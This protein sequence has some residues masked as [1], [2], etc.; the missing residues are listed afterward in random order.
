MTISLI[1]KVTVTSW[2]GVS[3]SVMVIQKKML[4][5]MYMTGVRKTN[6]DYSVTNNYTLKV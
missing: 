6:I 3:K 1:S 4:N 5:V 2:L